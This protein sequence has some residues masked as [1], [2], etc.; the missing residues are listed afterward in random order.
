MF[1]AILTINLTL[2]LVV[3]KYFVYNWTVFKKRFVI[4]NT[5]L[6]IKRENFG[7]L[8]KFVWL[9]VTGDSHQIYRNNSSNY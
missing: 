7:K 3:Q 5:T 8:V 2:T 6:I 4:S 9:F 1:V